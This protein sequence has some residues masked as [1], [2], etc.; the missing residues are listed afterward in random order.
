VGVTRPAQARLPSAAERQ[1]IWHDLE[2][3]GYDADLA[4]WREL[5]GG[6]HDGSAADPILEIGAGSGRVALDLARAGH[7][8]TALDL[9]RRLLDALS[10][11]AAGA[12]VELVCADARTFELSR[13]D[14]GLCLAAMQ[15]VQ[16][17]GG[18]AGRA[19]F[20]RRVRSHLR[21]GG[22]LACAIVSDFE[23]FDC[24]RD[25]DGP[26]PDVVRL[27]GVDYVSRPT[28]VSTD[29][30]RVVIERE[31]RILPDGHEPP[32]QGSNRVLGSGARSRTSAAEQDVIELDL[33]SVEQL[34]REGVAAG[35]RPAGARRVEATDEY[36]GS[37]VVV[38]HA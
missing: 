38:L 16:L 13:R 37:D 22:V 28:R 15:T 11:R 17:L 2:C 4:L 21:P 24:T 35:L 32:R 7:R 3:G 9:D 29:R 36:L 31:R 12:D 25:G 1:V 10:A 5:A 8:V 26:A 19:A 18:E 33:V 34:E 20:L 27:G 6:S 30:D 14:F 23:S